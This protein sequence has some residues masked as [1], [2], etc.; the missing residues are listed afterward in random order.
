M[1]GLPSE[2]R[3]WITV[4][5]KKDDE[6][7]EPPSGFCVFDSEVEQ[8]ALQFSHIQ[9]LNELATSLLLNQINMLVA[10]AQSY[11]LSEAITSS[12][13]PPLRK[14]TVCPIGFKATFAV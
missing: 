5:K 2:R 12:E 13:K 10:D 14:M 4:R 9:S 11:P 3:R 6:T 1:G 8:M 7:E